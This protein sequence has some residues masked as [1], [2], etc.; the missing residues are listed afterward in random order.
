MSGHRL[1]S[2]WFRLLQSRQLIY[3]TCW[4][5]PRLDREALGLTSNDRVVVITSAGC[6]ALDYALDAPRHIHAVDMNPRQNALLELKQ[7]AI[8]NLD[9]DEFFE[10]FGRGRLARWTALYWHKLR[11]ELSPASRSFWDQHQ[12]YFAGSGWRRSLYFR[13]TTGLVARTVNLYLDCVARVRGDLEALLA[14]GSLDEQRDIYRT[15]VRDRLW[16]P[17]LRWSLGRDALLSMLAVPRPQREHL[18]RDHPLGIAGFV[19]SRLEAVLT[20]LPLSDNYFWR[21]YLTGAYTP[22]CCPEYLRHENFLRLKGGLV[23]RVTT[24]TGTLER[25]LADGAEPV[26]CFVLLAAVTQLQRRRGVQRLGDRLDRSDASLQSDRSVRREH[27][28]PGPARWPIRTRSSY[29]RSSARR[30]LRSAARRCSP[31]TSR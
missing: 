8:R 29:P 6:N 14:A 26:T 12:D 2:S 20:E 21:V 31:S 1:V 7:A 17:L 27:L 9:Y 28:L 30:C 25:F 23:D 3:N 22:S 4:E 18:E 13:G 24:H 19:E 5:D 11:R 16:R 15:R 10:L